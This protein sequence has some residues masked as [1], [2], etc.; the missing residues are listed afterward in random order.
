MPEHSIVCAHCQQLARVTKKKTRFCS[1]RCARAAQPIAY[2]DPAQ[3][4]LRRLCI[5]PNGCWR[6]RG[7]ETPSGYGRIR[8]RGAGG[9]LVAAHVF[10]YEIKYGS[11]PEGMELD[12][13]CRNRWCCHPDHVEPVTHRTNV[14]R[15]AAPMA[16][17]HN[18][19][20]CTR[21]H[22]FN[23]ENTYFYKHGSR[24]GR[25]AFCKVCKRERRHKA[26]VRG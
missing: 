6:L 23:E 8:L 21:G 26:S 18:S 5:Q 4:F 1:L 19:G 2:C 24:K 14:L 13:T 9:K 7:S 12:H 22:R 10:A 11:V 25:V 17:I 15:G 3:R 16:Q 20:H